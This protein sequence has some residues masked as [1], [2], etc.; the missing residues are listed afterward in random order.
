MIEAALN[1]TAIHSQL[2][3]TYNRSRYFPEVKRSKC[4]VAII[5]CF[6]NGLWTYR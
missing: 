5:V 6:I 3:A 2:A 4:L 1:H